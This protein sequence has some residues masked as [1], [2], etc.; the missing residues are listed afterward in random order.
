MFCF[1]SCFKK[2][3]QYTVCTIFKERNLC[4][5]K[6]FKTLNNFRFP[7]ACSRNIRW[8]ARE[9]FKLLDLDPWLW[10][11]TGDQMEW[12]GGSAPNLWLWLLYIRRRSLCWRPIIVSTHRG[13]SLYS[14]TELNPGS[15][16][17]PGS[18]NLRFFS[19]LLLGTSSARQIACRPILYLNY[20]ANLRCKIN[21]RPRKSRGTIPSRF[22]R[23]IMRTLV[24]KL[25]R[26]FRHNVLSCGHLRP[27]S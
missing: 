1:N 13:L 10:I 14:C 11:L 17:L 6:N 19:S 20:F 18:R 5:L 3:N 23:V 26:E 27:K 21:G 2:H 8:Q 15:V 4:F 12:L 24:I 16:H 22:V 9:V 7:S 25:V